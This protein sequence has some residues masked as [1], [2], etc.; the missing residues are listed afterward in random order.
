MW[1]RFKSGPRHNTCRIGGQQSDGVPN[2]DARRNTQNIKVID[3]RNQVNANNMWLRNT[4]NFY[5]TF[6]AV[7]SMGYSPGR[8]HLGLHY[9]RA[10]RVLQDI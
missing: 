2:G 10:P 9:H 4:Y 3:W 5:S 8:L 6:I 1:S 7:G